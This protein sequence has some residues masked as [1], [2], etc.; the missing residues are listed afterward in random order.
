VSVFFSKYRKHFELGEW[1]LSLT[2]EAL[3]IVPGKSQPYE[4]VITAFFIKAINSF[5]SI[6]VLCKEGQGDDAG[7]LLR[8]LL[9]LA[10][11]VKWTDKEKEKHS[12]L[13]LGWYWWEKIANRKKLGE[14]VPTNW[15]AEWEKTKALFGEEK[16][17]KKRRNW[18]GN[19]TI[20]QLAGEVK[21]NDEEPRSGYQSA[22]QYHYANA[23]R[24]LSGIEHSNP[25]AFG[26]FLERS[27]GHYAISYLATD[28][29]IDEVLL[30]A[31]EYFYIII[32]VWNS[33]FQLI[34]QDRLESLHKEGQRYFQ[35]YREIQAERM[36]KLSQITQGR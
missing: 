29:M 25:L 19:Q 4:E 26:A 8:S 6:I 32:S 15:E 34:D 11:L 13:F 28:E 2:L 1:L 30:S 3:P 24:P 21:E 22:A 18:Y 36:K 31:F 20:F 7:L 10:F 16:E 9:N 5:R 27:K 33:H 12:S 23:Y 35:Q 14:T 17:I